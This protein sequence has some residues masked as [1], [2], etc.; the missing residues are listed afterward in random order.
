LFAP[1]A[2]L[3]MTISVLCL[4]VSVAYITP[5]I[6]DLQQIISLSCNI[7]Y[8]SIP[9]VYP[10]HLVPEHKRFIFEINPLFHLMRPLQVLMETNTLPSM[11]IMLKACLSCLLSAL[12]AYNIHKLLSR[13]VVYYL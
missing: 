1:V 2:I 13:R 7:L 5:Y 3:P 12:F 8:W 9:I 10:Y 6:S 4:S 11:E